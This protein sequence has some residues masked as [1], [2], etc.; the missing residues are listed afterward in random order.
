[1]TSSNTVSGNA[2]CGAGVGP[3]DIHGVIGIVKAY[4]T[5]VGAGPF[6]TELFD[7]I[8]DKLQSVGAEF[9]ATTGRRRRCGWLDTILVNNAVR[10]NGLTGVA[11]T[12][13]DVL[14]GLES[15]NICSAYDYKGKTLDT[16]PAN[17]KVLAECTPIYETLPGWQEDITGIR[18]FAD[19]PDNTQRYLK[20]VEELT[21]TP[22]QIVSVGPGRS[23]T[24][25]VE[26]PYA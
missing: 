9:G 17:L 23:Q 25:M 24:I 12:K 19:L 4:T 3:K 6:P 22:V 21:G 20:R 13:L 16:F 1:M 11:I 10:L 8:G 14:D 5:R 26:N 2:C 15:I 18:N 7:E